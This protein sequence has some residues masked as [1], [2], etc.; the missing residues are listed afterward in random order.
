MLVAPED[1]VTLSTARLLPVLT[2]AFQQLFERE[3]ERENFI[4]NCTAG[5]PKGL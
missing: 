3:R 1:C 2:N 5:I 4:C